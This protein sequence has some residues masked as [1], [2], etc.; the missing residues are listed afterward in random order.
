MLMHFP[1]FVSIRIQFEMMTL[2]R[3]EYFALIKTEMLWQS[4][5][6]HYK[7]YSTTANYDCYVTRVVRLFHYLFVGNSFVIDWFSVSFENGK[8]KSHWVK[9]NQ[10]E[11]VSPLIGCLFVTCAVVPYDC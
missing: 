5:P 9:A 4:T 10:I 7:E 3:T 2:N 8:S 1:I 6:F 11:F